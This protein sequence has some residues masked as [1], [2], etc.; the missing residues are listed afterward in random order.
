[1]VGGNLS[2]LLLDQPHFV[3]IEL[4]LKPILLTSY[5]AWFDQGDDS[6]CLKITGCPL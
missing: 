3:D 4:E 2:S 1:M 6:K 5:N